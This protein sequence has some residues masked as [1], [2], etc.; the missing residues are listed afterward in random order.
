MIS[1]WRS[2]VDDR[3][4][5]CLQAVLKKSW[6]VFSDVEFQGN[7][8][9]FLLSTYEIRYIVSSPST[10]ADYKYLPFTTKFI[11]KDSSKSSF[12]T[13]LCWQIFSTKFY[14]FLR[15][16]VV[17]GLSPLCTF[18]SRW[19]TLILTIVLG[20]VIPLLNLQVS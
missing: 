4:A 15:S 11:T 14:I 5:V 20:L 17:E 13:L 9:S 19:N 18:I 1:P 10:S 12:C 2:R 7:C 8:F 3:L 16:P 6:G